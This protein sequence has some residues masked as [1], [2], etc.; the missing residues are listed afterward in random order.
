MGKHRKPSSKLPVLGVSIVVVAGLGVGVVAAADPPHHAKPPRSTTSPRPHVPRST[1]S[2]PPQVPRGAKTAHVQIRSGTASKTIAL[3]GGD[4]V[5]IVCGETGRNY[6]NVQLTV[7]A[8]SP[9]AQ[10][11][12]AG[13]GDIQS[14]DASGNGVI[15]F[16]SSGIT[17]RY[18]APHNTLTTL[19]SG[20][21]E[22]T[23]SANNAPAVLAAH[24]HVSNGSRTFGV[25]LSGVSKPSGEA[26]SCVASVQVTSRR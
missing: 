11:Y 7:A 9:T 16:G 6:G 20:S 4:R 21:W 3:P 8:A 5:A 18:A 25:Y 12:V 22:L 19:A 15:V 17:T 1:T 10:I 24:F 2:P 23:F 13:T 14:S 26:Q